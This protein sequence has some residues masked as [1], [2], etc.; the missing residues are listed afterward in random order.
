[1]TSLGACVVFLFKKQINQKLNNFLMGLASGIM[2]SASIWSLLLPALNMSQNLGSFKILPAIVGLILGGLFL[3]L[4]DKLIPKQ[5]SLNY[6]DNGIRKFYKLFIAITLH[7]IPEGLSVGFV[8]GA[9]MLSGESS[10]LISAVALAVGIGIQN[11]PEGATVSL[12]YKSLKNSRSKAFLYGVLSG[13]VEPIFAI[14]GFFL[15]SSLSSFQPWLLSFSAGAMMF[16]VCEE[17]IPDSQSEISPHIG[18]WG[19][20][21]GFIIMMVLDVCLG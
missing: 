12:A 21:F 16:V 19:F 8:F 4:L 20:I 17:L 6:N 5:N 11:A 2:M 14:I 18:T 9:G 10:A 15:A 3:M 7:N 1:M 13:S